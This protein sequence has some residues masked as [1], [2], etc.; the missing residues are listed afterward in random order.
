MEFPAGIFKA[1]DIR[2][3]VDG[4]LSGEL[5]YR[6]GRA[7]VALLREQKVELSGK[8]LVVGWDMRTS[9][10]LFKQ[11]VSRGICDEGVDVA[12]IG[13]ASTPLF[14]FSC[15]NYPEHAGGIMVTAS[16]NPAR[17]NGFKLT[18]GSGLPVGRENG[19]DRIRDLV[20]GGFASPGSAV[21]AVRMKQVLAD[22]LDKIFQL[23]PL[24]KVRPA[25]VVI[26]AGN[27]MAAATFPE[28]LKRLP[29]TV[30][31]LYLEPDGRF[32]NHEA[33]PLKVETLRDLQKRVI[34][35]GADFGFALD[36][37]C[38][39]IGLV[40]DKGRVVEASVVGAMVGLEVLRLHPGALLLYDLRSSALVKEAWENAGGRTQMC[41]VGHALIKKMM[42]ET[43]AAYASELSLHLYYRDLYNLESSDLSLLYILQVLGREQKPLSSIVDA[44]K[45][46][47]HSEEINFKIEDKNAVLKKI[48]DHYRAA[49]LEISHL[50][51]LWMKL[52]WGWLSVRASNTEPVLRLN[53]ET[54]TA[55][56]TE[57]KVREV[58]GLI[59]PASEK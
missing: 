59:N 56:E 10:P 2:G 24:D 29:I 41:M 45:K 52:P 55:A 31:Y 53:L 12:D 50:D 49:A 30:E 34:G 19:M 36:G 5:A 1:Y 6:V 47:F 8:S 54:P 3:L 44:L 48:E 21:G 26:D 27:G 43:G 57:E 37:D 28:L 58:S 15:A 7:F 17:Y 40:D 32:P 14:N 18:M 33:N 25:K 4:E 20:N 23:A 16:H 11:E 9:S 22:Y 13:E 39:R 51:G 35:T 42:A 46:Y 38:D